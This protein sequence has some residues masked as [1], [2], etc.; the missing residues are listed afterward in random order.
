MTDARRSK[1][2]SPVGRVQETLRD[3]TAEMARL[4][5]TVGHQIDLRPGDLEV[6]DVLS[7]FGPLSPSKLAEWLAIHPATLTG[8]LDRLE[9]GGWAQREPDPADRR[10]VLIHG[11]RT[12]GGELR[13]LY[14]PMARSLTEICSNYSDEELATIIDFMERA[15]DA[16]RSATT[17]V[18]TGR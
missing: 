18:A 15:R 13:R 12:R 3:L 7:R 16:G 1:G 14:G 17:E 2:E 10:G 11:L 6:L 5:Q 8:V 9:T 4:N